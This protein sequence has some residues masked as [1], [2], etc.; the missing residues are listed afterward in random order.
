MVRR[1]GLRDDQWERIEDLLP[2]RQKSVGVTAADNWLFME[3]VLYRYRAGVPWRDLPER[4]GDCKNVHRRHSRW[5]ESGVWKNLF[6]ALTHQLSAPT[7]MPPGRTKK[8]TGHKDPYHCRCSGQPSGFYS[9]AR[10]SL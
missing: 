3:A 9:D 4:F 2:G 6:K 8:G 5:F 10:S 7:S 1:Y